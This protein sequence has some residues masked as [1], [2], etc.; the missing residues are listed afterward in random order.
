MPEAKPEFI[1]GLELSRRFYREAVRP[2]LERRFPELLHAAALLGTGSEVLGFDTEMSTDHDWGPSVVL[3]LREADIH[4]AG[5]ISEVMA[6]YLPRRFYGYPTHS[7]YAPDEPNTLIMAE[8]DDGPIRHRVFVTSTRRFVLRH[9]NFDIDAP[10]HA[11]DWLT[12]PSQRLLGITGGAVHHDGTG[13]VTA[14]RERFAYYPHDIW[15]YL[16]AAGWQRIG[17]EEPFVG[18][19]GSVGDEL[20]SA[21]IGS[22]LVRDAMSLGF[23]LERR[24]A[25]Y[26]K[27]FGSAFRQ[28]G[29]ARDLTPVL[30]RAQ[31][32]ATWRE[33]EAALG[34]AYA[35]LARKQNALGMI[36]AIPE[37]I[38][39]FFGRP[40]RVIH[41]GRIAEV[42]L[43]AVRDL[44]VQRIAQSPLIGSVDQLSDNTDLRTGVSREKLLTLYE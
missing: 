14:M 27:W 40:Y 10:L 18:R 4:L 29:C 34:E 11:V 6:E 41:G 8:Q 24:Y 7:A 28:L 35:Y 43:T 38:S 9:L 30:W 22:R 37:S 21:I 15:L 16:L 1:G 20:G 19:A 23:L 17:E 31:Q 2:L 25:P 13:E 33:R 3:F 36:G 5:T 42:I 39:G 12:F 32:A 26:A 44:E